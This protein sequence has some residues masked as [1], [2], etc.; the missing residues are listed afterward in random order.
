MYKA[1]DAHGKDPTEYAIKICDKT[2]I[3][4]EKKVAAIMRE[5]DIMNILNQYPSP[6]FVRLLAS[7]QDE[8]RLCKCYCKSHWYKVDI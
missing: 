6:F 1:K 8:A 7:F 3:K 2:F 4:K 5:K